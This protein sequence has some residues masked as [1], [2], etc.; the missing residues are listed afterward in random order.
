MISV[1]KNECTC[2]KMVIELFKRFSFSLALNMIES[3]IER[4]KCQKISTNLFDCTAQKNL[5]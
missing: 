1:W 4:E 5:P 2:H 3:M